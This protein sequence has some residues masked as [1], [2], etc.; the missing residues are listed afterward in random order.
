MSGPDYETLDRIKDFGRDPSQCPCDTCVSARD[1]SELAEVS[2][3]SRL[4]RI[5]SQLAELVEMGREIQ[6]LKP[7]LDQA[8][9]GLASNP[10]VAKMLGLR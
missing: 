10:L 3:E 2:V 9:A 6:A 8:M 4:A 7:M 5:E 1:N